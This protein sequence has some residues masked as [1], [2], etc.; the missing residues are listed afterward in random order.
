MDIVH[1]THQLN[2]NTDII[3]GILDKLVNQTESHND[4]HKDSIKDSEEKSKSQSSKKNSNIVYLKTLVTPNIIYKTKSD[5]SDEKDSPYSLNNFD[6]LGDKEKEDF[7]YNSRSG[8]DFI[9][10]KKT[11]LEVEEIDPETSLTQNEQIAKS[12][13]PNDYPYNTPLVKYKYD[14]LLP[15]KFP[16]N[17][18]QLGNLEY[19]VDSPWPLSKKD[20]DVTS[21]VQK[22]F[23]ALFNVKP[24]KAADTKPHL[25]VHTDSGNKDNNPKHIN[26]IWNVYPP[27]IPDL[28]M[29][30]PSGNIHP[31]LKAPLHK[32][33]SNII[34]PPMTLSPIQRAYMTWL[35]KMLSS[36]VFHPLYNSFILG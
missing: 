19:T 10:E 3:N 20:I 31:Y 14:P 18:Y 34:Y 35:K 36:T 27:Y 29:E 25:P 16:A 7:L 4:I 26:N 11:T 15:S 1:I 33:C 22:L 12:G 2:D 6:Q 9:V 23:E 5:K 28:P 17:D 30:K 13:D 32:C 21:E 8:H 24:P